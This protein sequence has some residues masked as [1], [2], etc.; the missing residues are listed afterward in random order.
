MKKKRE[1]EITEQII[2]L[3]KDENDKPFSEHFINFQ[4]KRQKF[5]F[6]AFKTQKEFDDYVKELEDFTR[7]K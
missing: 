4:I 3:F 1:D 2:K 6:N 5:D 7:K